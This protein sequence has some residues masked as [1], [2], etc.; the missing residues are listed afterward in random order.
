MQ[1]AARVAWREAAAG[2]QN[3]A[4]WWPSEGTLVPGAKEL[5]AQG[6]QLVDCRGSWP[7]GTGSTSF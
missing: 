6:N 5:P 7:T 3:P 4:A 1:T 2:S